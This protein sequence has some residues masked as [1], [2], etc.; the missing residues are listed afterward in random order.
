MVD[1]VEDVLGAHPGATV[2]DLHRMVVNAVVATG[3]AL[4][5]CINLNSPCDNVVVERL[6]RLLRPVPVLLLPLLLPVSSS[7]DI[8][9]PF[10]LLLPLLLLFNKS[11]S[12]MSRQ[13]AVRLDALP[14]M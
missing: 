12:S 4:S 1:V 2:M 8:M 5:G 13:V 9:V 14:R 11:S 7:S 3:E 6:Q 10:P